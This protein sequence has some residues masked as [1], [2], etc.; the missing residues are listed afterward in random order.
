MQVAYALTMPRR[1][2]P[3]L[4]DRYGD[5]FTVD[6]PIF[7]RTV[8]ISA[9]AEIKQLFQARSDLADNLDQNLGQV[10]GR[11][12]LFALTGDEH[13][14]RR[15]LLVPPF[16]G[17]R[18]AAY[19]AVVE[20]ETVRELASW[21]EGRPFPTLP[22]MMRITLNVILRAV[23]GAEGAEFAR[24]RELLPA[25][26]TLGSRLAVVP[27][28]AVDWGRWSPWGRFWAMRR[29]YDAVVERLITTAERD[30][31]LDERDDILAMLM[32]SRYHDG[33]PM[34][35]SEIADELLTL[36][37][38]GHE[39]TA[40]TLA[41][42]VERIRRH[43]TVLRDLVTEVDAG[44]RTL[45]EATIVEVQ[46]TRPVIDLVGRQVKAETFQLGRWTIP[47]GYAV[48]VSIALIHDDE[49][50]FPDARAFDPSRF[51]DA[52]PDLY[53]WIPFGGGTRRC[54]G[55]A[56][57]T[58]EMDVVLRTLLRE[59][60]VEPTTEPDE[61]WRS[62]GIA[63]APAGGGRVIVRRRTDRPVAAASGER[64]EVAR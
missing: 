11:G 9:P 60:T 54:V 25:M 12:S 41:W 40:T 5:A 47:Q 23:F 28:P 45:R 64:S 16:H 15:K 38:A 13:R 17:R 6:M 22:S 48:L 24:L 34:S 10:L 51:V 42:A 59:F 39:T 32:Q 8:V 21:P 55:A 62:R 27:V 14:R 50:L 7:G 52:K 35:R 4:R 1:G 19:E 3:R 58:M 56:F 63:N 61:R 46:R 43:P 49:A 36:L 2:M 18:L 37:A 30:D 33:S 53:Q 26:I 57:A 20:E 29:E 44:G 31:R